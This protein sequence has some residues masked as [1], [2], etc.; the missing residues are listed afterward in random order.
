MGETRRESLSSPPTRKIDL[1]LIPLSSNMVLSS[2][3]YRSYLNMLDMSVQFLTGLLA[4]NNSFQHLQQVER[5]EAPPSSSLSSSLS[6]SS[7]QEEGQKICDSSLSALQ[8][9]IVCC[10]SSDI[11]VS[12]IGIQGA[13]SLLSFWKV[14]IEREVGDHNLYHKRGEEKENTQTLLRKNIFHLF[15]LLWECVRPIGKRLWCLLSPDYEDSHAHVG[16]LLVQLEEIDP[17][18][19]YSFIADEMSAKCLGAKDEALESFRILW[20]VAGEVEASYK[21]W[22]LLNSVFLKIIGKFINFFDFF[23]CGIF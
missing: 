20:G 19:S 3:H 10:F 23:Y 11:N 17:D 2:E 1:P 14:S 6:L 22:F 21:V 8:S 5:N 12:L 16:G 15:K 18:R 7:S 9:L 13:L 4:H